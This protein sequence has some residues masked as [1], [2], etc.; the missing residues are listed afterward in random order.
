MPQ[1]LHDL[2]DDRVA[3]RRVSDV[4]LAFRH[5]PLGELTGGHLAVHLEVADA[6]VRDLAL[7]KEAVADKISSPLLLRFRE[8]PQRRVQ[9]RQVVLRLRDLR[10]IGSDP[11]E[12]L[13]PLLLQGLNHQRIGHALIELPSGRRDQPL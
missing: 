8:Q 9:V 6:D 5:H 7:L 4:E 13:G 10:F 12:D 3:Q 2:E 1:R 11:S